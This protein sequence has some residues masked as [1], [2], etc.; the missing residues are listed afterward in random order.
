M[1][2]RVTTDTTIHPMAL[3]EPGAELGVGVV[4]GP[5]CH[6]E[7]GAKVGDRAQ[8]A[9][10]SGFMN[11]VPAGEV[12]AGYPAEPMGKMLRNVATLRKLAAQRSKRG[13]GN[14]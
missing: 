9:A 7:A 3:V 1:D 2:S 14:D 4:I 12:W 6:V 5:F 11:N 8:L 10:G 13:G